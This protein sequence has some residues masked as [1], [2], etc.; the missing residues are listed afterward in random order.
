MQ[1]VAREEPQNKTDTENQAVNQVGE[2]M[3]VMGLVSLSDFE[4]AQELV[5]LQKIQEIFSDEEIL[6]ENSERAIAE[7]FVNKQCMVRIQNRLEFGGC[8]SNE[9]AGGKLWVLWNTKVKVTVQSIKGQSISLMVE[10]KNKQILTSFV[11]AKCSY[12]DRRRLWEDLSLLSTGITPWIIMGDFNIIRNNDERIGGRPR[13]TIAMREFNDFIDAVGMIETKFEGNKMSWCNGQQVRARSWA[14]LDCSFINSKLMLEF[15]GLVMT[16][17]LRQNSDHSPL[18]VAM[19]KNDQPY[20]FSPFKFQNMWTSHELF[21]DCVR[22]VWRKDQVGQGMA[23]LANKL[24]AVKGVL[25]RWNKEVF[26]WTNSH[27]QGLEER[28]CGLEEKLQMGFSEDVELDLLASKAELHAWE[29]REETRLAQQA[30]QRWLEKGEGN[31]QFFRALSSRTHRVVREMEIESHLRLA[32][33]LTSLVDLVV[34]P[35]ENLNILELP[36]IQEIKDAIFSIPIDSSPRPDGFGSGF[37]KSCWEIFAEDVVATVHDF[38]RGNPI[39]KFF[40]SSFLVLIPKIENPKSFDKFRPISLCSVF[41]KTCSKLLVG[42]L[43]PLL[44]RIVSQEQGAFIQGRSILENISLTQEMVQSIN[45]KA[46]GGNVVLKIDMAKAYDS[47]AWK[48]LIQVLAAFGFSE[49][50]CCLV[51]QCISSLWYSVV[52]NATSKGFFQGGCGLR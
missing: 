18:V 5:P 2:L 52:M 28:I 43:A 38:F 31:A 20:G 15:P 24:K 17:L 32:P 26:G 44:P 47:V 27:I 35:A 36:S 39:P 48:F 4:G 51:W 29:S 45:K 10:E 7:P 33:D 41:Y 19:E 6:K 37:F 23:K 8:I 3:P 21:H 9:E 13:P 1:N 40:S 11:Y 25:R 42:R 22:G 46:R 16:Y 14:R 30:K 34:S 49:P 12:L 50:V